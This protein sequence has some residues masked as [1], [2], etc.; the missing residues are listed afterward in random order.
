MLGPLMIDKIEHQQ[1][2]TDRDCR[3][4]SR[5][6]RA[7]L[8]THNMTVCLMTFAGGIT[9]GL[10]TICQL[11]N[12]GFLMGVIAVSCKQHH[13]ALKLWSFVAAH[14]AVELP[15]IFLSGAAGLRLAAGFLFPGICGGGRPL[16]WAAAR[17]C[18]CWRGRF[19]C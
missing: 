4:R 8:M 11:V 7:L 19:R 14:G 3:S 2:W 16:R 9:A 10:Y 18:S 5:R 15:S 12:N 1:M 13:M 6:S 17:P